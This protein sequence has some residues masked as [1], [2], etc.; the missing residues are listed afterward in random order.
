MGICWRWSIQES[1]GGEEGGSRRKGYPEDYSFYV[2]RWLS[3]GT[4]AEETWRQR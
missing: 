2:A 4:G 1:T 3:Q